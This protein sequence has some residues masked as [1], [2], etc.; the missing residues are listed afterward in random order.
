LAFYLSKIG[1]PTMK[2]YTDLLTP[3]TITALKNIYGL[4][5][6]HIAVR[7]NVTPQAVFYLLKNDR[8]KDYQKQIILDLLLDH[9]LEYTELILI[10]TMTNKG[11]KK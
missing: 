11:V 8:L 2:H 6:K 1:G 10:N 4:S 3:A 5:L 7:L 9:G